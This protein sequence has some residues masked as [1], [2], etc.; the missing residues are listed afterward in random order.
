METVRSCLPAGNW[1]QASNVLTR[2]SPY[3]ASSVRR[4]ESSCVIS[5][6]YIATIANIISPKWQA[7]EPMILSYFSRSVR[8]SASEN[9][10]L[11]PDLA[12]REERRRSKPQK[13]RA[14]GSVCV[15]RSV[16]RCG[17]P[18]RARIGCVSA[19]LWLQLAPR[20]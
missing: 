20:G 2:P 13:S 7:Q 8:Q 18:V 6:R 11:P 1:R 5:C 15:S 4:A 17:L 16:M 14:D 3:S 10:A 9:H 12:Q 19:A